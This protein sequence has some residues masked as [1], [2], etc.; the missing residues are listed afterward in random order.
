[1]LVTVQLSVRLQEAHNVTAREES[2]EVAI[3]NYRQL[4]NI[5]S[6]H[7]LKCLESRSVRRNGA[8]LTERPHHRLDASLRP[9]IA[10]DFFDFMR[11]DETNHL[12]IVNHDVTAEAAA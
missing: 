7:H 10:R 2:L 5:I 1:M 12:S 4:V 6:T 9:A 3:G 8:D 11:R